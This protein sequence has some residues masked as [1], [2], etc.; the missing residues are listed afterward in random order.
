M[1]TPASLR[2]PRA[3]GC[4]L[5]ISYFHVV[6]VHPDGLLLATGSDDG[7]IRIW[8]I[9]QVHSWLL[10]AT[11]S[12]SGLTHWFAPTRSSSCDCCFHCT[13]QNQ[14]NVANFS[15]N[16][17][18]INGISFSENGF[19]MASGADDGNVK[20]SRHMLLIRLPFRLRHNVAVDGA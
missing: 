20:A 11:H 9:K 8:D 7:A 6:Q 2:F 18:K 19:Y 15:G 3:D 14:S 4:V 13:Q 16:T 12:S 10:L 1:L 17:A 5:R